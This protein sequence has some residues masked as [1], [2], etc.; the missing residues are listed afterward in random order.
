MYING[1][2][3]LQGLI[4]SGASFSNGFALL[5]N[6]QGN[7]TK[8]IDIGNP[9]YGSDDGTTGV[10][11]DAQHNIYISGRFH[12]V[13]D[14]DPSPTATF[15]LTAL[16][17]GTPG[18][19]EL[20]LLKLSNQGNFMWVTQVNAESEYYSITST[21]IHGAGYVNVSNT[22]NLD[23]D[24]SSAVSTRIFNVDFTRKL[25]YTTSTNSLQHS[26]TNSNVSIY[27]NP[28]NGTFSVRTL[29]NATIIIYNI[30]G[31]TVY[32]NTANAAITEVIPLAI[33]L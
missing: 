32:N 21:T 6:T 7:L 22:Q 33:I 3:I 26:V 24:P 10:Y 29:T 8:A 4:G 5:L 28:N 18:N 31:E 25:G 30:L 16:G 1:Q 15:N 2:P 20:Y 23:L 19:N 27:P 9:N 13:V 11:A 17:T 12:D 14:F